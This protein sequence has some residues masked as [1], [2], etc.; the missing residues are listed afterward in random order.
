[1]T[2]ATDYKTIL[3]AGTWTNYGETPNIK[4]IGISSKRPNA[5]K[6]VLLRSLPKEYISTFSSTIVGKTEIGEILLYERTQAKLDAL[7]AD[8]ENII[9]ASNDPAVMRDG[10][11]IE[12]FGSP[13]QFQLSIIVERFK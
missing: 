5:Y 9:P 1:M 13:A 12:D 6:G 8:V 10:D 3:E 11:P 2:F 7:E 4:I